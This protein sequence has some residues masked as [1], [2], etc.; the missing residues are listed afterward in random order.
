MYQPKVNQ[1][2]QY[3]DSQ[4]DHIVHEAKL[5]L[6]ED[7]TIKGNYGHALWRNKNSQLLHT[8]TSN[9][10]QLIA[11]KPII[12]SETEEISLE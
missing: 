8:K 5:V 3:S 2:Q 9:P 6:I 7:S 12:I 1:T 11:L 4:G 10:N